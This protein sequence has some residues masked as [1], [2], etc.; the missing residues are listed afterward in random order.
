[1]Q[2][3]HFISVHGCRMWELWCPVIQSFT[4]LILLL[5]IAPLF[6][7]LHV[8]VHDQVFHTILYIYINFIQIQKNFKSEQLFL[9]ATSISNRER[10]KLLMPLG[11]LSNVIICRMILLTLKNYICYYRSACIL[12]CYSSQS[13][14]PY[15]RTVTWPIHTPPQT[16]LCRIDIPIWQTP[17]YK[18]LKYLHVR[19]ESQLISTIYRVISAL[20]NFRY[21]TLGYSIHR[22]EFTQ[23]HLCFK[24]DNLRHWNSFA[25]ITGP[26]WGR[27]KR[28]QIF[29]D[30]Q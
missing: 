2:L 11:N 14:K 8:H 10:S 4:V 25:Q 28:G 22:L 20:C 9:E 13:Y 15:W 16:A 19:M 29:P 24:R 5:L 3:V 1:M 27:I 12:W 26:K 7:L 18:K 6:L 30:I 23:T 21:S 17:N